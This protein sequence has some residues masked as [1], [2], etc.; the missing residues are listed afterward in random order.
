MAHKKGKDGEYEII[1]EPTP[2]AKETFINENGEEET[3]I[4]DSA[5]RYFN[6]VDAS[7]RYRII[8][9][10]G[11]TKFTTKEQFWQACDSYFE[12]CRR[13]PLKKSE[14]L[15]SGEAMGAVAT[16]E[17]PRPF[18]IKGLCAFIGISTA[19]FIKYRDDPNYEQL[20][21]IAETVSNII[22]N[23]NYEYAAIREYDGNVVSKVRGWSDKKEIKSDI[24][25]KHVIIGMRVE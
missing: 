3:K 20:N 16:R 24:E 10:N 21:H 7:D 15:K 22:D 23:Q 14:I 17:I 1:Y 11:S 25:T 19:T 4:V 9:R 5:E 2:L 18:D 6:P 8:N 13:T 12:Y